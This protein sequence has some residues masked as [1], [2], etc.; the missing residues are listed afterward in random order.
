MA[1]KTTFSDPFADV[2]IDEVSAGGD[3]VANKIAV[4]VKDDA[5]DFQLAGILSAGYGL[6]PNRKV[7]DIADD[8][9]SRENALQWGGHDLGGFDNIKTLFDGKRYVDYFASKNPIASMNGSLE[10][11]GLKLGLMVWNAYDGTRKVGFEVFALNPFCTNQYHSRN[12]FG[13][14]AWKHSGDEAGQIDMDDALGSIGNGVTNLIRVAPLIGSLKKTPL[15]LPDLI[16]AKANTDVPPTR[17]GDVLDVLAKETGAASAQP[18]GNGTAFDLYQA[19]TNVAT[20]KLSGLS[21]IDAGS[22]ITEHFFSKYLG[23][24]PQVAIHHGDNVVVASAGRRPNRE[25]VQG[26]V[27]E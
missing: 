5:G 14:F 1:A 13:Y 18:G 10:K 22:S 2:Q 9:M 24:A 8:V 11:A 16:S 23:D 3:R 7:R 6:I 17:W 26:E 20:H 12:R 15:A 21:A 25:V 27:V 4:R 19:L